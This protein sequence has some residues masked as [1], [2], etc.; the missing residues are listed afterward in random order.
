[1]TNLLLRL[2]IKDHADVKSPKV[3]AR[4]GRFAGGVGILCNLL[5]AAAKIL[6]G[7]LLGSVAI[8]ADGLN[9]L[10]DTAASVV[11][12]IGFRL[13]QS[14]ADKDHPYG[15]GRFEYL[16]ALGVA[17]LILFVGVELIKLSI[18]KILSPTPIDLSFLA[19]AIL[20]V[21]ILVK[22][23]MMHFFKELW[24]RTESSILRAAAQDSRNDVLVTA[25]TLAGC[26][27]Y[28]YTDLNLDGYIGLG[29]ALFILVSGF[30]VAKETIS[31]LLGRRADSAITDGLATLILSHDRI[32]GI[33]DLL[34]HDYG[35][36]QCY[37]T[38]HA[39]ISA[40]ESP[41]TC[42]ELID[43]IEAATLAKMNVHLV[44]HYDPVA[45]NDE[46]QNRLRATVEH[47][48]SGLDSH[49]SI[50][51]FRLTRAK[52]GDTLLFDVSIPYAMLP[53][54][55]NIRSALTDALAAADYHGSTVI[56]FDA[57]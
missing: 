38:V 3:R 15:H 6:V 26:L 41:L 17:I 28:R 13:A 52:E 50:H 42:H 49:L 4:I 34:V 27:I 35:P 36:G 37:A 46:E 2:F 40:S 39:E 57:Y 55:E 14:P 22:L 1:M 29:V 8:A 32:L 31:P 54:E 44:I 21:S 5:L 11:A 9:N 20:T 33:H 25:A 47:T 53:Q 48:L 12:V 45:E 24:R 43:R 19:V 23:F 16:S 30:G 7:I 56:R 51:D 18:E 10:S